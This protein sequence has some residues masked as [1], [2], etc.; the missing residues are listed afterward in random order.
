[1]TGF[2]HRA[3]DARRRLA[4]ARSAIESAAQSDVDRAE[5]LAAL[6]GLV[7]VVAVDTPLLARAVAVRRSDIAPEVRRDLGGIRRRWLEL[8]GSLRHLVADRSVVIGAAASL[9]EAYDRLLGGRLCLL[10]RDRVDEH[11]GGLDPDA[12]FPSFRVSAANRGRVDLRAAPG[13]GTPRVWSRHIGGLVW[14]SV[15]V[16]AD[17][18]LYTGHADSEFVALRG[19]G[20]VKW[21]RSDPQMM[22]VD[23]TGAL[24]RDGYLYMASTDADAR[25]HQNQGRIWKLD[26]AGGEVVWTFWGR[27]FEDPE[28]DPTAHLSSYF[29]G[30]VAL[31]WE[32]GQVFVYAGSDDNRLY[33]VDS[34]GNA[35]WEY[36]VEAHPAGIIWTK[37]LLGPGCETV[38]VGDLAGGVHAVETA[39][40]ERIWSVRLGGAVA[41]SIALG[42]YGELVC[43]SFDGRIQALDA[44]DGSVLW[45]YQTLG[46]VYSSPAVR[47]DGAVVVG[48]SDAGVY[49]IDRYGRR[50]WTYTTDAPV[51]SSPLLDG[52]DN[53][54]V[55]NQNGKLYCIGPDGRRRWSYATNPDVAQ[56]DVNCSPS[57][58]RDGTVY[59]GTTT[60]DVFGIGAGYCEAN[61]DDP[62]VDLDPGDDGVRPAI[63]PGGC[64]L[65]RV[66]RDGVP[67]FEDSPAGLGDNLVFALFATDGSGD[68]V[69][70]ALSPGGLHVAIEPPLA[71]DIRAESM[72][73]YLYVLPHGLA[74]PDAAYRLDV[75]ATYTAGAET[76]PLQRSLDVH[77]VAA[78]DHGSGRFGV[79]GSA[80]DAFVVHDVRAVLPKEI[81]AVGQA[82]LDSQR[83]VLAPLYV[84]AAND[85]VVAAVA[86][87]L[88]QDGRFAY[89][90]HSTNKTVGVGVARNGWLCLDTSMHMVAQGINAELRRLRFTGRLR[91]ESAPVGLD[92][93]IVTLV[94]PATGAPE[95]TD[96][97]RGMRLAD[98]N[99][100]A[101]GFLTFDTS[102]FDGP[103]ARRPE[104]VAAS[105]ELQGHTLVTRITTPTPFTFA[106]HW[107]HVHLYDPATGSLSDPATEL[108][109]HDDAGVLEL[110][111]DVSGS[112][113]GSVAILAVDLFPVLV[114]EL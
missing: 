21:R 37:P 45:S 100:D 89:Q 103:A 98:A 109:A 60:G 112:A 24:G 35:V 6:T 48:S 93:G 42:C 88:Q 15:L 34:D 26:P 105:S 49:C 82:M 16:A 44:G 96:L 47:S 61:P 17:G 25:G 75:H 58:G 32:G 53:A 40:G 31:S 19:D 91:D 54:Y 59:F 97:L 33:K 106:D 66:D 83:F 3:R 9:M 94:V 95:W 79:H 87:V 8:A 57:M 46:L 80:V 41:S 77:T 101:V 71:A 102:P 2:A 64:I 22:Y 36:D 56:N 104:G 18:D 99:D 13:D 76:R 52:D 12:P 92:D 39:G 10:E 50:M 43:G 85:R 51:K 90:P 72:G 1:M 86:W 55:G 107:I 78:S 111:S 30:N 20:S 69:D 63:E 29:E 62:A 14:P 73:R 108:A 28:T 27:H 67:L 113:E 65:V 5:L 110:R 74:G 11:W 23:S 114:E 81:D 68:V 38:F 7:R 4:D 70:A 84:D